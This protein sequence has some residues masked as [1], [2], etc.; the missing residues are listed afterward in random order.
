MLGMPGMLRVLEFLG[1][2]EMPGMRG[3]VGYIG[4]GML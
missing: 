4:V 2:L 3:T 1:M